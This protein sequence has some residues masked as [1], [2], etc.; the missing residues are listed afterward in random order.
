MSDSILDSAGLKENLKILERSNEVLKSHIDLARDNVAAAKIITRYSKEQLKD[1][2]NQRKLARELSNLFDSY[3]RDYSSFSR[4]RYEA[5]KK[6]YD[7]SISGINK[8]KRASSSY[9]REYLDAQ[10][11]ISEQLEEQK[12]DIEATI[13]LKMESIKLEREHLSVLEKADRFTNAKLSSQR[14]YNQLLKEEFKHSFKNGKL[15]Q[16]QAAYNMHVGNTYNRDR[17]FK[18]P[19]TGKLAARKGSGVA[20]HVQA[21][22]SNAKSGTN[23]LGKA[24]GAAS[25]A[26]GSISAMRAGPAFAIVSTV[27]KTALEQFNKADQWRTERR[28]SALGFRGGI[29]DGSIRD[30]ERQR[31]SASGTIRQTAANYQMS[32]SQGEEII[33]RYGSAMNLSGAKDG[34]LAKMISGAAAAH[35]A[36]GMDNSEIAKNVTDAW[37]ETGEAFSRTASDLSKLA[38]IAKETGVSTSRFTEK[39]LSS[40]LAMGAYATSTSYAAKVAEKFYKIQGMTTKERE[41]QLGSIRQA[42]AGM[43][44]DTNAT[45]LAVGGTAGIDKRATAAL[46]NLDKEITDVSSS[47][48]NM[49]KSSTEYKQ[50]QEKLTLMYRK[51]DAIQS[52]LGASSINKAGILESSPE[53]KELFGAGMAVDFLKSFG[54]GST[55]SIVHGIRGKDAYAMNK[56]QQLSPAAQQLINS[57]I[58]AAGGVA[59]RIAAGPKTAEDIQK[60]L[61]GNASKALVDAILGT[62]DTGVIRDKIAAAMID[63]QL[64]LNAGASKLGPDGRPISDSKAR[65][66]SDYFTSEKDKF[67]V[68]K[69]KLYGDSIDS[70]IPSKTLDVVKDISTGIFRMVSIMSGKGDPADVSGASSSSALSSLEGLDGM[71]AEDKASVASSGASDIAADLK[72]QLDTL[73][74][75]GDATEYQSAAA[76]FNNSSTAAKQYLAKLSSMGL[77]QKSAGIDDDTWALLNNAANSGGVDAKKMG[78]NSIWSNDVT[79]K[80]G[81]SSDGNMWGNSSDMM[82]TSSYSGAAGGAGIGI[83]AGIGGALLIGGGAALSATGVGSVAGVPM[84]AWGAGLLGGAGAYAGYQ[85]DQAS[86]SG[87][88]EHHSLGGYVRGSKAG[89]NNLIAASNG[90]LVL[91][92]GQQNNLLNYIQ[93]SS[94]LNSLVSGSGSTAIASGSSQAGGGRM[95]VGGVNLNVEVK[96]AMNP[97][98]VARYVKAVIQ[99]VF[100]KL[101]NNPLPAGYAIND[102]GYRTLLNPGVS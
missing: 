71:S 2:S 59:Q 72:R 30:F 83:L 22:L 46:S 95:D 42:G 37:E 45:M 7:A 78:I 88:L 23:A 38:G 10:R 76:G 25:S 57:N 68:M 9:F 66:A 67:Q 48:N 73:D 20:G 50:T 93:N 74:H 63:D 54:G 55:E 87:Q 5:E 102:Q 27:L 3:S 82:N 39:V 32:E 69:D 100:S 64:D 97:D 80:N 36:T 33:S 17:F 53:L 92:S 75:T 28:N 21:F 16:T 31:K 4:M 79:F 70:D 8:A 77:D 26:A 91:N 99:D 35:F 49:D 1:L 58:N 29:G 14:E 52:L 81:K 60:A 90:E 51:K 34:D 101:Q 84:A 6:Y 24:A 94:S 18:D 85:Y 65:G 98:G 89:D 40:N 13:R 44:M 62:S 61:G 41:A 43:D 15:R 19:V 86:R 96:D 12:D 47:L 56:M 11:S